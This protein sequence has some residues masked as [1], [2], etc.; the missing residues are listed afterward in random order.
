[1][2]AS[3]RHA[4]LPLGHG[5]DDAVLNR[6]CDWMARTAII[7]LKKAFRRHMTQFDVEPF[8]WEILAADHLDWRESSGRVQDLKNTRRLK[9]QNSQPGAKNLKCDL[10]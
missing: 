10:H 7:E 3:E 8:Q 9:V 4:S 6:L 1:M 5:V 2:R